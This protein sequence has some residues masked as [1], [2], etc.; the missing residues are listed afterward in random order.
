MSYIVRSRGLPG[1]SVVKNLS[2]EETWV[3]SLGQ[4][5]PLEEEMKTHSSP[6]AWETPWTEEPCGIQSVE[7]QRVVHDLVTKQW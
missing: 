3:Q 6:V 2:V 5:N 4:E 7:S 1:G